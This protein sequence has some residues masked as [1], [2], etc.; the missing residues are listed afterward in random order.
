MEAMLEANR[1][2][3]NECH[4]Y[5]DG[6]L[7]TAEADV[8]LEEKTEHGTYKLTLATSDT[9]EILHTEVVPAT[10]AKRAVIAMSK[11]ITSRPCSSAP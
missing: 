10:S 11:W 8:V 6:A 9:N 5:L 7:S 1:S 2:N 3:P 4:V